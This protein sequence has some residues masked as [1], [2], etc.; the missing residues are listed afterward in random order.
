MLVGTSMRIA[1]D[2]I[3]LKGAIN[4]SICVD[5]FHFY[6]LHF[7]FIV[8]FS[9]FEAS[10][11]CINGFC[12]R[13]ITKFVGHYWVIMVNWALNFGLNPLYKLQRVSIDFSLASLCFFSFGRIRF[14]ESS[15][16]LDHFELL[17]AKR[18]KILQLRSLT[19]LMILVE[20]CYSCRWWKLFRGIAALSNNLLVKVTSDYSS[21]FFLV[22]LFDNRRLCGSRRKFLVSSM[23]LNSSRKRIES[24][25]CV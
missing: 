15:C 22:E 5:A 11:G 6:Q 19:S 3:L 18:E 8:F 20:L 1:L 14:S 17:T 24:L 23:G 9:V 10:L 21:E 2:W 12:L 16:D 25:Y 7:D 13:R 4:L